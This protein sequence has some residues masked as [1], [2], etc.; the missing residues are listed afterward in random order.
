LPIFSILASGT[1]TNW[2]GGLVIHSD[3]VCTLIRSTKCVY[4][5]V[6]ARARVCVF[7]QFG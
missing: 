4:V 5:R 6:R 2:A 7:Y 3:L 1:D